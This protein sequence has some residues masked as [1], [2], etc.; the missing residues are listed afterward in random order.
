M[1][2]IT[3]MTASDWK[4]FKTDGPPQVGEDALYCYPGSNAQHWIFGNFT[5]S[6]ELHA[7][8]GLSW[9]HWTRF[10]PPA[11]EDGFEKWKADYIR[12]AMADF[13]WS[14]TVEHARGFEMAMKAAW[15]EATR[16]A[17]EG[18]IPASFKEWWP[19][20]SR[21]A[22][23]YDKP[24]PAHLQLFEI[25]AKA[26]YYEGQRQADNKDSERLDWL[27]LNIRT[28]SDLV[29]KWNLTAFKAESLR[30]FIDS[31]RQAEGKK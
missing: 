19:T 6:Q 30:S 17:S 18:P 23:H 1:D 12:K 3:D 10:T 15:T 26:A 22:L 24:D 8:K 28:N 16:Q 20:Y 14:M 31:L 5:W 9:T 4:N 11:K 27:E 25:V 29:A 13:A 21:H 2:K 7:T